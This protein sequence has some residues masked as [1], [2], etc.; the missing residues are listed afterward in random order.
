MKI[1][2]AG[3]IRDHNGSM[4]PGWAACCSGDRAVEI[5]AKGNHSYDRSEVTCKAC[6]KR[7]ISHDVY[8]ARRA[9]NQ[10]DEVHS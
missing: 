7:L 2:Y 1:H 5:R 8:A 3:E 6:L 9:A 4:L 10:S